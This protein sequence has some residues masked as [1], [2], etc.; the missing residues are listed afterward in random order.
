LKPAREAEKKHLEI[1]LVEV[2][3]HLGIL[4][5]EIVQYNEDPSAQPWNSWKFSAL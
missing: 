3:V 5:L 2:V 1:L 4:D